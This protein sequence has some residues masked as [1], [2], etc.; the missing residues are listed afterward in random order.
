METQTESRKVFPQSDI[1]VNNLCPFLR[2]Q[3]S[4]VPTCGYC[5]PFFSKAPCSSI[6]SGRAFPMTAVEWHLIG[7]ITRT[8]SVNFHRVTTDFRNIALCS[9]QMLHRSAPIKAT[10]CCQQSVPHLWEAIVLVKLANLWKLVRGQ[11]VSWYK[12][13]NLTWRISALNNNS[14][15]NVLE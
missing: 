4:L 15:D 7:S 2:E 11:E 12:K 10:Q 14:Y 13:K 9:L 6:C 8:R 3:I 1:F 5:E